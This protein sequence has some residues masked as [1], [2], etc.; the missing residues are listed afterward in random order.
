MGPVGGSLEKLEGGDRDK[1][2]VGGN[3]SGEVGKIFCVFNYKTVIIMSTSH[4]YSENQR[5]K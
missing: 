2:N 3:E 5:R 1:R 4:A